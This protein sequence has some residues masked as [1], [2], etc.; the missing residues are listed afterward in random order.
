[1]NT[2]TNEIE[3]KSGKVL[4]VDDEVSILKSLQRRFMHEDFEVFTAQS[5][6]EAL[7][8]LD[9][10]NVDIVI[11]DYRMPGMDGIQFLSIAKEKHPTVSR[12]IL[13]GFVE[14]T[15]VIRSLTKGLT[16]TYF[17]KPWNDTVLRERLKHILDVRKI[18]RSKELL[19]IVNSVEKLPTLPSI[20]QEFIDAVERDESIKQIAQVIEKD[21]S[22]STKV[23][24]V[25]NSAFYG[26]KGTPAIDHAMVYLGLNSVKDILLTI[27]LVN[28]MAWDSDQRKYLE[29][30]FRHSTLVNCY[31]PKVYQLCFK[32][33]MDEQ[34]RSV[35]L[36]HDIGKIIILQYYPER[37][38]NTILNM[39]DHPGRSFYESELDLGYQD[40]SHAEIGAYFLDWWNLPEVLVEV[41]LFHHNPQKCSEHYRNTIEISLYT[42]K[43]LNHLYYRNNFE[44]SDKDFKILT[45]SQMKT[46]AYEMKDEILN[47]QIK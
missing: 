41:A 7:K 2:M 42:D 21:T 40:N 31:I 24:Q 46:I 20:Y 19:K 35:G 37:Y 32:T 29:E 15:E 34:F 12:V 26:L 22:V 10:E 38:K 11:T 30:I 6:D 3:E 25:A 17:A 28:K 8:I 4:F 14:R 43:L 45:E 1:M 5:G 39:K 23:L 18:L 33:K 44:L 27:T 16:T 47:N 9:Q 36:T 13:S